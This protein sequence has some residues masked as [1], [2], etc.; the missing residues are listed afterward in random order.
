MQR[1]D[2]RHGAVLHALQRGVPH[3]RVVQAL[4]GVAFFQFRQVQTGAEMGAVAIDDSGAHGAGHF[5]E[6]VAQREDQAVVQRV[7]LGRA[8]QADH[9]HFLVVA[10]QLEMDVWMGHRGFRVG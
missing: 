1:S 9:G 5:L 6:Q 2:D 10:A 7:A 4:A 8:G 3:A